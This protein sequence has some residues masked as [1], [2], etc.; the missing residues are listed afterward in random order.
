MNRRFRNLRSF[1]AIA[2]REGHQQ[3][4]PAN[5]LGATQTMIDRVL[6]GR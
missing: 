3:T 4:D 6:A 2:L 5:Y 1:N